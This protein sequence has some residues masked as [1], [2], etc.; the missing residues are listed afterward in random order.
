MPNDQPA[1]QIGQEYAA[2]FDNL[3]HDGAAVA[4]IGGWP[5]FVPDALPGE[6]ASVRI[7]G[8][9]KNFALG[10]L[11]G[12]LQPCPERVLP[13]CPWFGSCG[14]C[15]L[16]HA[17]YPAQLAFKAHQVDNALRRIGRLQ[18][19]DYTF[20]P[21]IGMAEPWHYRNKAQ[22]PV[23]TSAGR[24][25]AGF[26]RRGSHDLVAVDACPIQCAANNRVI[27]LLP[28]LCAELGLRP[29]MAPGDGGL[30]HLL[31]RSSRASGQVMVSLVSA[32]GPFPRQ[33][34]LVA[35][36]R[37]RLPEVVSIVRNFNDRPGSQVS[38][39]R[40]Q[41]LWGASHLYDDC[42]GLR[43]AISAASFFQVNPEQTGR[44]YARL[45]EM[46]AVGSAD[47]VVDAYCGIGTIS[48][49][50]ARQAGRVLGLEIVPDAI[51]DA[52]KNAADNSLANAEFHCGLAE[53]LLPA[54]QR[55]GLQPT[56][57]V[58]DPPRAG[59]DPALLAA[60]LKLG[61]ERLLYVSCDPAT[62]ARD[63]CLLTQ[64]GYAVREV[65]P[66]DMFPQ[67]SHIET[68]VKL[69]RR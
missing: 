65:Q 9:R 35:A 4:R 18:P 25:V 10:E 46:A 58:V 7:S 61:P 40:S 55:R 54:W 64:G 66:V 15:Q 13:V 56:V 60:L 31:V 1:L 69:E 38:G 48:L 24:L 21:V 47:T 51:A 32:N 26:Y 42:A 62:L 68:L 53:R 41:L 57:A 8:L 43:F 2:S 63:L 37:E 11:V 39:P 3:T 50:L 22:L 28:E 36:I 16:Q 29:S 23:G 19:E 14:G 34:D 49:L 44:L 59:C 20:H 17:S 30:R 6:K 12:S 45:L 5:V 52:R 27:G 67:T 33:A